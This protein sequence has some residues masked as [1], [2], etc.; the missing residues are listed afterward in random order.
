MTLNPYMAEMEWR[1]A[2]EPYVY[3]RSK[4][5]KERV[6]DFYEARNRVEKAWTFMAARDLA[7]KKAEE[8]NEII[9][10]K[11][12]D[13]ADEAIK[14]LRDQKPGRVF[15]LS[16]VAR[17][18]EPFSAVESL[19]MEYQPYTVPKTEITYPW[20]GF[21]DRVMS[22]EN[23]G[24]SLV[25]GDQPLA[26]FYVVV[27]RTRRVPTRE[28]FLE[29]YARSPGGDPLWSQNALATIRRN[30]EQNA[31]REMRV[32]AAGKGK[33]DEGGHLIL[34]A[35]VSKNLDASTDMGE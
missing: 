19:N 15:D 20:T 28:E 22:L 21:V 1:S 4:D 34:P 30:Y 11:Y 6:P 35:N 3:W 7:R 12:H 32:N 16:G 24:D 8:L 5:E 10:A 13:S 2:P 27:L 33:V 26:H 17:L 9:K 31:M 29:V 23:K 14:F 25:V 18:V